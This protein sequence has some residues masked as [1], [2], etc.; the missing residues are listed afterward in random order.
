[1]CISYY[2]HRRRD[3]E[4]HQSYG[5]KFWYILSSLMVSRVC[6]YV[7]LC[8]F[9]PTFSLILFHPYTGHVVCTAIR[10]KRKAIKERCSLV[11][12]AFHTIM[13]TFNVRRQALDGGFHYCH[14]VICTS[15]FIFCLSC[16]S[17]SYCFHPS[18]SSTKK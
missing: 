16:L 9:M 12:C 11:C 1:M 3:R 2:S 13:I 10:S 7:L 8:T 14:S 5:N 6:I 18:Y 4:T 15:S 17:S